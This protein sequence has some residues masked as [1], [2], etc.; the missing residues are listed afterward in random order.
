MTSP[1]SFPPRSGANEAL[2][3][4]IK[5]IVASAREGNLETAYAGYR[6]LFGSEAFR[7]YHQ[8]DRRQALRLMVHAKG[9]PDP[10][11]PAMIDAHRAAIEPLSQLASE[12]GE[13]ADYEMLGMCQVVA[14]D[15]AGAGQSFRAG[16]AIERERNLQSDLCGALMKRISML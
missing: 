6:D 14:G 7:G 5:S 8:L 11:T 13:P 12:L 4:T 1:S 10:P 9:V 15:E 3:A 16:L 2:V